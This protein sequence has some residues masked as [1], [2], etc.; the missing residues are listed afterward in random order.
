M[1]NRINSMWIALLLLLILNT[2]VFELVFIDLIIF[3]VAFIALIYINKDK[4]QELNTWQIIA[5]LLLFVV[6][7]SLL[8]AFFYFIASPIAN[9]ITINWLRF[10]VQIGFTLIA[11]IPGFILLFQ[12][13]SKITKGKFPDR[14]SEKIEESKDFPQNEEIKQLVKEDQAIKAIKKAREIYG[15]SLIEAKKY[16]DYLQS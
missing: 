9:R 2:Y 16:I 8:V 10:I 5:V 11:I 12:G 4:I 3:L 14:S 1:S 6:T 13:V 15:Y 7:I